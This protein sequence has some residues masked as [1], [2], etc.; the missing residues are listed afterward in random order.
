L[1]AGLPP[2]PT[3]ATLSV[4][5]AARILGVHP[6]T[7]RAWSDQ[8]RL[9][10][11]R[12]NPRGDRRYRVGD[13]QGFLA[14]AEATNAGGYVA[15]HPDRSHRTR[16]GRPN[17]ALVR[18]TDGASVEPLPARRR[19]DRIHTGSVTPFVSADLATERA[20]HRLDLRV[21][22]ELAA[23][24]SGGRDIDRMLGSAVTLLRESF[25][26]DFVAAYER[27]EDR[28]VA[29]AMRGSGPTRTTELP[30]GYGSAGRALAD[31]RPTLARED[32]DG[33]QPIHPGSVV[34]I[35]LPVT[36]AT[37]RWGALVV[38]SGDGDALSELDIPFLDS[39]ARQF[40]AAVFSAGLFEE[41]AQQVHRLDALR[42]VA[43]DIG[44]KLDLDQTLA[45]LVDHA[46]VLFQADRAAV[47][48]R[49]PNGQVVPAVSRGLSPTYLAAV[50]DFPLPSL[51]GLA[52]VARKP[53]FATGYADDPRG[54]GVRA[55][56]IQEGIDTL[57]T[58]PLLDG[59]IV[60]GL[61]NVYHDRP[62]PW[63][64]TELDT[65]AAFAAQAQVAI[66]TAQDYSQMA[67]W[68]AQLQ[69]IQQLGARLNGLT[70]VREIGSAIATE[71]HQLIDYH[72]VRVYRLRG[73]DDLVPV[74]FQGQ[75]G[76]YIDETPD[77]LATK[78]GQGIT[79]WVAEHRVAQN[80]PDAAKDP[81]ASTI[82]GTEEDLDE[83]M[84]LAPMLFE[85]AILGVVVLSKLGLNQFSE[86]DLRLLTIYASFAAQAMANADTNERLRAQTEVLERQLRS[87]RDLLQ[88]TESILGTLDTSSVLDQITDR[89][90][91][92]VRSDNIAIELVDKESGLLVPLSA[93]GVD[94]LQYLEPWDPG[95][96]GIAPWV[97]ANNEPQLIVDEASDQRV[98]HFRGQGPVDGSII[99]VPLRDREGA[100]G[101]LTLE[102]LGSK[103]RYQQ[104]DFDLVQL[105]A[106][107]VSIALENAEAFKK[108]IE[109]AERDTLT[110]LFNHGSFKDSLSRASTEGARFSLV[111]ID[112]D[113]FKQVND[114]MGHQA[115]DRL[116]REI[117]GAITSAGR[118]SDRVFRYGG[119]E[120][121]LLLPSTDHA[122]AILV[123]ERVRTAVE[124]V[125]APGTVWAAGKLTI[126]VSIG[127]AT[128]PDDGADPETILLAA[129]RACFVAKRTGRGY[130]ATAA[131]GLAL[132]AEFKLQDPTPVD[133]PTVTP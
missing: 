37:N 24:T 111:M 23:L 50:R 10:Y 29:R 121:A 47:F 11:Y 87:Q 115:G 25:A 6:N 46:T 52:V 105:F 128:F 20:R 3:D 53:M 101:V 70:S 120:I 99:C 44:S 39:V 38:G 13:L 49:D 117:A 45:G 15:D 88:I 72:N 32:E 27:R 125:G 103:D 118:E 86:D 60:L 80:L 30:V 82:A 119:D 75:V 14:A 109:R 58:A 59:Q 130:I 31:D 56:V 34:E 41:A 114:A 43:S 93:K 22:A 94:A 7:I 54:S 100:V 110:G 33:W 8:G 108:Q 79:G 129:D 124:A 5:K 113:D 21:L 123:A 84:L 126:S 66:K 69:S 28:L 16:S 42:R 106:A 57:C 55:A 63:T 67:T 122:G 65:L 132:A 36:F 35:A 127:V 96:K 78:V 133:P 116:L 77:Q 104:A 73:T 9:R 76:E 18:G 95:E 85:D 98:N 12:I 97:V 68:A 1:T 89:L 91:A 102:R 40:A 62:H 131:Q 51:P 107:H 71:L 90:N 17:L 4:T 74:A 112:I 19:G 64:D 26:L 81:R 61:L 83:S 2:R 48:L 92:L